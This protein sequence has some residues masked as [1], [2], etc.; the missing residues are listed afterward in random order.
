MRT[1]LSNDPV[2]TSLISIEIIKDVELSSFRCHPINALLSNLSTCISTLFNINTGVVNS[3][4]F[5]N[6]LSDFGELAKQPL[7]V[8]PISDWSA[9]AM[10][11]AARLAY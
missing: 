11:R 2:N 4:T 7:R 1:S 5:L 9:Y 10:L 8:A 3:Y 6:F